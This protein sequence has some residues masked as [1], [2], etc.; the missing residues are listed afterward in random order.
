MVYD[1]KQPSEEAIFHIGSLAIYEV[2][3][4]VQYLLP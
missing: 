1:V 4:V 3:R 2:T